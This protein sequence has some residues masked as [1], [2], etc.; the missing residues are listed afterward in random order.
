MS[1]PFRDKTKSYRVR[2]GAVSWPG[3]APYPTEAARQKEYMNE[4]N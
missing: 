2:A 4:N 3:M 1:E